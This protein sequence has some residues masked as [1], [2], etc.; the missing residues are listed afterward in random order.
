MNLVPV[1][2][3]YYLRDMTHGVGAEPVVVIDITGMATYAKPG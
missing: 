1:K 2:Y 3:R